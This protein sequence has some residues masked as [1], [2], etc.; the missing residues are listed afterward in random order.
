MIKSN[1]N[2]KLFFLIKV[3]IICLIVF[4]KSFADDSYMQKNMVAI[5]P[6]DAIVKIKVFSSLTCP[7]CANFHIKVVPEIKKEYIPNKLFIGGFE[8]GNIP[9]LENKFVEGQT[10]I[11]VC[12]NKVCQM[13]TNKIMQAIKL[14]K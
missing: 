14:L 13:P 11:Y 12:E 9:L 4:S 5:G 1:I 3:C 2:S 8:K 6:D 7:H 10:M